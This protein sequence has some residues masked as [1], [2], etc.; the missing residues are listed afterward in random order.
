[1]LVRDVMSAPAIMATPDTETTT[2]LRSMYI[3][4]IHR[5]PVVNGRGKLVGIVTQRDLL[6]KGTAITPIGEI[7][8]VDPH[9]TSPE[10]SLDHAAVLLRNLAIGALPVLDHEQVVG[11]ITESDIFDA[12]LELLGVRDGGSRLI[13]QIPDIAGGVARILQA[14][15]PIETPLTGLTAYTHGG[16]AAVIVTAGERDPRDLVRALRGAGFDPIDTS[17]Q[18]EAALCL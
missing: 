12:F 14:L 6:Q 10:V 1:M 18:S 13:V 7:M 2:A 11:I 9:T 16:G 17:V 4:K 15:A 3:H 8:T 5:L